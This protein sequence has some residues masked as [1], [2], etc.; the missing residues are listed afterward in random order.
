M[1][2]SR[3]NYLQV[4][5][6][7]VYAAI[8]GLAVSAAADDLRTCSTDQG[9][10]ATAACTAAITSGTLHGHDLAVAYLNRGLLQEKQGQHSDAVSDLSEAIRLDPNFA[11]AF[12]DRGIAY[13]NMGQYELAVQDYNRTIALDPNSATAYLTV[14]SFIASYDTTTRRFWLMIK[15]SDLIQGM[16]S[17]LTIDATFSQCRARSTMLF[18]TAIRPLDSIRDT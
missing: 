5:S 7:A 6:V 15:R 14:A 10:V 11:A 3:K 17:P 12:L 9:A 4:L 8:S 18:G 16:R 2:H 13:Q 1:A